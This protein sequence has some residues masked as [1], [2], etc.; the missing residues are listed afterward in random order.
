MV[1][2][3]LAL[4]SR[5]SFFHGLMVPLSH[6]QISSATWAQP[7]ITVQPNTLSPKPGAFIPALLMPPIVLPHRPCI[8]ALHVMVKI[9]ST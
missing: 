3:N 8:S 7:H 9:C 5:M 6:T 1:R 4:Y 2:R